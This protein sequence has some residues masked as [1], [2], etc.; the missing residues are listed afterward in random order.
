MSVSR[1]SWAALSS[2]TR[3]WTLEDEEEQERERR[4]R[5]R[6]LSFAAD[7]ED[8]PA[9]ERLL[10]VEE[11]EGPQPPAPDPRD[12]EDVRA[13]LRTR[14][15]RRQRRR[16]APLSEPREAPVSEPREAGHPPPAPEERVQSPS[17]RRLSPQ[18]GSTDE[19]G[20]AG[21]APA[22]SEKPSAAGKTLQPEVSLD[23]ETP[24]PSKC[25]VS[26]K[27]AVLDERAFSGR[28]VVPDKASVSE[29]RLVSEKATVFEKTLA[30]E[31]QLAPGRAMAPAQPQA[32]EHPAS[33]ERL[34]SPRGQ[35]G[36]G[37]AGPEKEPESSAGPLPRV[38]SLP[39][40]TLQ[41]RTRSMEAEAEPPSPTPASPTFSSALQR[42]SPRTISFRMSPRRDSSEV[43]LTRSASVRIPASS[44]KLGPKLERY[45]SAIQRSGSVKS[46]SPSRTEFL[47]APVDVASKRHLFEKELVGQS[48]EGPAS[49]RKNQETQRESAAGRRPQ[50][51]KKPEPPLG[52]EVC[53]GPGAG[54]AVPGERGPREEEAMSDV[55][56]TVDEYE[57]QEEH[58]EAV[59]EEAGGE[60]EAGEPSA[61]EDGEEEE[62]RE[63][64]DGPVE[65]SKPKPRPFMPNLVPPKIPDGERVDFD[66]IH[67]KRMEKDLNE[68]QTLIEAHFENRKKEEEELV[69]LKD[70]IEKRRAERA[71]QQRIRT[72]RE[73]ERQARL[74][75]ER[76]RREEEESRRKA[77]DEA[78]KKKALSNMMH[79]GGYI[80]KAQVGS[81][82]QVL[83]S[84]GEPGEG[85]VLGW[86]ATERKS[87]KRQ[88]EREKK[89]KILAERRKVLAIDHLNEDQLREKARELWQSIYDLE[90][91]KFDLQEK[92]KQQ[93]YEASSCPRAPPPPAASVPH[94]PGPINV[95]RNRVND[96]QKVLEQHCGPCVLGPCGLRPGRQFLGAPL[97]LP[98]SGLCYASWLSSFPGLGCHTVLMVLSVLN[99]AWWLS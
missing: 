83:L 19:G 82:P 54:A 6:N 26:Q 11:A 59:E 93:K 36:A 27:I 20:L 52:A 43:A 18:R 45:H 96:N 94:P 55:E 3:Q 87:G 12:E 57:E 66:D 32:R 76:A 61:A 51:R 65:E 14:Q 53:G 88:T 50:W 86:K 69:S 7:D 90:A 75:E 38:G 99:P 60:A 49:S 37:G 56:E 79:F 95:L 5:H 62:G 40:V 9:P 41:V 23:P 85:K 4:R 68:L 28:R 2:L 8:P 35:R 17:G 34:P 70:R 80:Q 44:V 98:V 67:R 77:E 29:K 15:E 74:A 97:L 48:R 10:S 25:S 1:K 31:T 72:E 81:G 13:V 71:E 64:E 42:S 33:V 21:R 47:V 22:G 84:F 91:E 73:K 63:A 89:K 30:P 46:S 16:E 78:R 58:E 92:F 39:P 24:S